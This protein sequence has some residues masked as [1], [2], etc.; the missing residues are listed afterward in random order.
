MRVFFFVSSIYTKGSSRGGIADL[1][2]QLIPGLMS[3]ADETYEIEVISLFGEIEEKTPFPVTILQNNIE[4]NSDYNLIKKLKFWLFVSFFLLRFII[5]NWSILRSSK[6][7][8]CSPG[9]SFVLPFFFK[10]VLIWE[11]VSF[12]TK[13]Y[14]VARIRFFIFYFFNCV[15]I[16]PTKYEKI[17]LSSYWP[18]LNIKFMRDWYS[19]KVKPS[20]RDSHVGKIRFMSAG[21]LEL[22]KGFDILLNAIAKLPKSLRSRL[23]FTIYGSGTQ[24]KNLE[25]QI[26]LLELS[27]NVKLA[28]FAD[29][30]VDKYKNYDSFILSSRYEGF[31]L[32]MVNALA[33]GMPV[34]AFDCETGPAE[35]ITSGYNGILIKEITSDAMSK[36]IIDFALTF[37]EDLYYE[38]CINSAHPYVFEKVLPLWNKLLKN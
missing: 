11:N 18:K 9:P 30:L 10:K 5:S 29:D 36:A 23:N 14:L 24:Y 1:L 25:D 13:G 16:V 6:L 26:M 12:F 4:H 17:K 28:G 2:N 33:S 32:V 3:F 15:V 20:R 35:I 7:I 31:P 27:E 22:R 8:S 34:L 37:N 21:A 38:N 19:E